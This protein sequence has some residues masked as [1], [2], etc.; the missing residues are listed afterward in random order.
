MVVSEHFLKHMLTLIAE[1]L[2]GGISFFASARGWACDDIRN[3]ELVTASGD[4]INVNYESY[5]DLYWA[6]RGGGTNFGIVTRFDYEAFP[7]GDVYGGSVLIEGE[8]QDRVLEVFS[9]LAHSEDPKWAT[10]L[11]A[12]HHKGKKLFHALVMYSEPTTEF[13]L[14]KGFAALPSLHS[15]HKVR[16]LSDLTE[17]VAKVQALDHRQNYWNHTF[18]FDADFITWMVD[19]FY[20]EFGP[21]SGSY[22]SNQQTVL[23]LQ[24]YTKNAVRHM[25]RNGGNCLSLREDEAPYVNVL[26]PT[27]W[28]REEDDERVLDIVRK[29]VGI[30]VDEG[31]RRGLY[32]DYIYMNY[33]SK[34]QDVLKGY[35]KENYD[36]LAEVAAKYD[37]RGV[38]QTLMPGYFKLGGAPASS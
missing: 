21:H 27:A 6:L 2:P 29:L 38:F 33:G 30:I 34:Y 26:F 36:R 31:K 9:S 25:A 15:T 5:P 24:Y 32:V 22:E 7:Q 4:I 16:S 35:G 20:A 1:A 19:T 8:Y 18:K 10:W 23:L 3:Y 13:D 37:P 12:A 11:G 28:L 14:L 17:E